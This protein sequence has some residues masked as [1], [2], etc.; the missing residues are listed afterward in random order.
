MLTI[1]AV[2]LAY[3][4][5]RG[6]TGVNL[7]LGFGLM[8]VYIFFLKVSEVLGAVAGADPLLTVW[9]PNIV[10]GIL[11]LYLYYNARK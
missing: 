5:R 8:F 10:F 11:A 9:M 4:K 2:A 3:K 7:A 6:G 1:I